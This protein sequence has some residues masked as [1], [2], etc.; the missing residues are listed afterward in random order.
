MVYSQ[1]CCAERPVSP[2][3]KKEELDAKTIPADRSKPPTAPSNPR[4][5]AA[6][7]AAVPRYPV[8]LQQSAKGSCGFKIVK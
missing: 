2:G 3:V 5:T 6:A 4:S 7:A 1:V 8:S